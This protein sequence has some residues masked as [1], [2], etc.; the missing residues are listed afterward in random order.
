MQVNSSYLDEGNVKVALKMMLERINHHKEMRRS[1]C[2]SSSD[3]KSQIH[4]SELSKRASESQLQRC[5]RGSGDPSPAVNQPSKITEPA[6]TIV[7]V[8]IRYLINID[9][10]CKM[11]PCSICAKNHGWNIQG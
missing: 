1:R 4:I 10:G 2:H 11:L 5:R 3:V 6:E 8:K 9:K 7:S